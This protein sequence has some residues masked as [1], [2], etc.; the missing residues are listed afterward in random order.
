MTW[1]VRSSRASRLSISQSMVG[2]TKSTC[3]PQTPLDST[4]LSRRTSHRAGSSTNCLRRDHDAPAAEAERTRRTPLCCLLAPPP[5]GPHQ[6]PP[7]LSILLHR[8]QELDVWLTRG[9]RRCVMTTARSGQIISIALW[10]SVVGLVIAAVLRFDDHPDAAAILVIAALALAAPA[11]SPKLRNYPWRSN[12]SE[13]EH[14]R[15]PD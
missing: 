11:S 6:A 5:C 9:Y 12:R 4:T 3:H 8:V 14:T 2:T 1:T 15:Q 13:G 7:P 10:S